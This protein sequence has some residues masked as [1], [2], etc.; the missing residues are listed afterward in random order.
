VRFLLLTHSVGDL[1]TFHKKMWLLDKYN[2]NSFWLKYDGLWSFIKKLCNPS[3]RD[4]RVLEVSDPKELKIGVLAKILTGC[5]LYYD[6]RE[7][8]FNYFYELPGR[9]PRSLLKA[10]YMWLQELML[11]P[12]VDKIIACDE[13]IRKRYSR[14]FP[15]RVILQRAYPLK[16]HIHRPKKGITKGK[17]TLNLVYIGGV[18]K[19]R[20]IGLLIGYVLRWNRELKNSIE[21]TLDIY[22]R[23]DRRDWLPIEHEEIRFLGRF[24]YPKVMSLLGKYDVGVLLWSPILKKFSHNIPIK[25]YDYMAGGLPVIISQHGAAGLELCRA[26]AGIAIKDPYDYLSFVAAIETMLKPG[27]YGVMSKAAIRWSWE[28][29]F[30]EDSKDYIDAIRKEVG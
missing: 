17:K 7:D 14:Y 21:L 10:S 15:R 2:I 24:P 30:D 5:K 6:V 22:G 20:G 1:R 19:Y 8:W 11:L 26:D 12:F 18:T 25:L 27:E 3:F 4:F 13:W 16:K 23:A 29:N 9:S 28:H